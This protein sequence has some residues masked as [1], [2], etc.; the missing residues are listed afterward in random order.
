MALALRHLAA[1]FDDLATL[2]HLNDDR[3]LPDRPGMHRAS[4]RVDTRSPTTYAREP[5]RRDFV[6]TAALALGV[7]LGVGY[8]AAGVI[9]W[10]AD[11]TDGD[12][13]DLFFWLLLLVGGGVLILAGL[14]VFTS[15]PV[16]SIVLVAIG[17]I[18]GA[19]A[20]VWSVIVPILALVLIALLIVRARRSGPALA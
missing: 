2:R 8:I 7:L 4:A 19:L 12:G 6:T 1:E 9:G 18:A 10:I 11:A 16:L 3:P 5:M 17:A 15:P 14:F 13:S 20:L